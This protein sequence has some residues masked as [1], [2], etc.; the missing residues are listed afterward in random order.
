MPHRDSHDV[1]VIGAGASGLTAA[2]ALHAAGRDTVCLEAR[3]RIGGRMLTASTAGSALDLGATWFW[4][5]EERVAALVAQAGIEI[6][7]QHLTGD[8]IVQDPTSTAA[9]RAT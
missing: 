6:F 1:V 2:T 7:D 8:T 4:D 3:D 5:G 9:S